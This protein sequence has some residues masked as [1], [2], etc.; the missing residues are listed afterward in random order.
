MFVLD[1]CGLE[2]LALHDQFEEEAAGRE[3]VDRIG[4][5]Y[6]LTDVRHQFRRVAFQRPYPIRV[7]VGNGVCVLVDG[8]PGA[9]KVH[10]F[11]VEPGIEED[12]L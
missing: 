1:V 3:D 11:D 9:A 5:I 8:V 10:Q 4:V 12:V 7:V 6:S 2:G